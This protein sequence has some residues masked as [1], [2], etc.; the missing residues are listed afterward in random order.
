MTDNTDKIVSKVLVHE[1]DER[2]IQV[3]EKLCKDYHLVGLKVSHASQDV[4]LRD[5]AADLDD[6]LKANIDLGAV[7][8]SD[9][10]TSAGSSCIEM[11]ENI[12]RS[13]PELPIF[14]RISDS[15]HKPVLPK[16]VEEAIAGT[17]SLDDLD[18]LNEMVEQYVCSMHYPLELA[19]GIQEISTGVL[20]SVVDDVKVISGLP[21]L[22]K[23]QIIYGELFSL[24]P[25]ESD[26]CRGYMMLQTTESELLDLIRSQR[27]QLSVDMPTSRD[28]TNLLSE[29]TNMMWGGIKLRYVDLSKSNDD[30]HLRTQVP[31][32]VNH[33]QK[34]MSFGS[35][36]PQLCFKYTLRDTRFAN[37]DI[38]FYQRLIFNLSWSPENFSSDNQALEALVDSGEL[39]LF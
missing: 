9:A 13:R 3:I 34:H 19:Q 7:F 36:E 39:E 30:A 24:I 10:T 4:G 26:W 12:R 5:A 27:T 2:A 14:L 17:Y 29:I 8:L 33:H 22:V 6:I 11:C 37:P 25:L 38:V 31:I 23:D 18:A 32:I 21:Y 20:E 15:S 35:T 1:N 28:S 16:S